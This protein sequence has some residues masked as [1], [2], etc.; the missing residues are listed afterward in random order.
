MTFLS[1]MSIICLSTE[2][3]THRYAVGSQDSVSTA[4]EA[5]HTCDYFFESLCYMSF[6]TPT[7]T[8]TKRKPQLTPKKTYPAAGVNVNDICR[9]C[10]QNFKISGG[11]YRN[12]FTGEK[13]IDVRLSNIL[14]TD[15]TRSPHLSSFLCQG[16]LRKLDRLEKFS[17]EL[18]NFKQLYSESVLQGDHYFA[19]LT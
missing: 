16:C 8:P 1:G 11:S 18:K 2:V 4:I 5:K 14:D 10:S 19:K 12:I 9:V 6:T 13:N 3:P 15:I 7:T 17:S